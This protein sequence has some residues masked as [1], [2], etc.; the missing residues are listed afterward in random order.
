MFYWI[1]LSFL[2][3]VGIFDLYLII[4]GKKTISQ[5]YHKLFNKWVDAVLM[6]TLLAL[7]WWLFGGVENFVKILLGIIGGHLFWYEE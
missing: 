4:K 5:R 2:I 7:I 1:I 6:I 3:C